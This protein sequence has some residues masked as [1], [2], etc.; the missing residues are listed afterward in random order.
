MF[1]ARASQRTRLRCRIFKGFDAI[2]IRCAGDAAE[3]ALVI[4]EIIAG[5]YSLAVEL[6]EQIAGGNGNLAEGFCWIL[7]RPFFKNYASFGEFLFIEKLV[8]VFQLGHGTESRTCQLSRG[9]AAASRSEGKQRAQRD[10]R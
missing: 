4:Q 1:Q 3:E 10:T 6:F 8:S 9:L 7:C 2:R 5:E